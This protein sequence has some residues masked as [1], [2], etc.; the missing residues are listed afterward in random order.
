MENIPKATHS[1]TWK[2]GKNAEIEY[3]VM[4]NKERGLPLRGGLIYE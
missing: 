1:G 4:D 2:I 3:Y